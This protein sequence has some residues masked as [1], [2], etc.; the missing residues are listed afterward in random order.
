MRPG[1]IVA[2]GNCITDCSV[3]VDEVVDGATVVDVELVD[4]LEVD[5]AGMVVELDEDDELLDE[6]DVGVVV[7]D[8]LLDVVVGSVPRLSPTIVH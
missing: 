6:E 4:E 1:S 8:E 2:V 3:T 7:D 5:E